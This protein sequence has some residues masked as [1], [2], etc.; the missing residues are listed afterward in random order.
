MTRCAQ[1]ILRI[2]ELTE[3]EEW[4]LECRTTPPQV[5]RL[6]YNQPWSMLSN[7][8]P[9]SDLSGQNACLSRPCASGKD[10]NTTRFTTRREITRYLL[11]WWRL[12]VIRHFPGSQHHI[13]VKLTSTSCCKWTI[14]NTTIQLTIRPTIPP[15]ADSLVVSSPGAHHSKFHTI[16]LLECH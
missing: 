4:S 6:E 5:T 16:S 15:Q 9:Y 3:L 2:F 10:T 12:M 1:R 14:K 7:S 8:N 13:F 11:L